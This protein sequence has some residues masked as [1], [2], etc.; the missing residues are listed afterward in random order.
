M[1]NFTKSI[2]APWSSSL[3]GKHYAMETTRTVCC[4][5]LILACQRVVSALRTSVLSVGRLLWEWHCELLY[6]NVCRCVFYGAVTFCVT[7]VQLYKYFLVLQNLSV[8]IIKEGNAIWMIHPFTLL[9]ALRQ[10]HSVFQSE[11]S[12]VRSCASSFNFQYPLFYL[13]SS[14]SFLRLLPRLLVTIWIVYKISFTSHGKQTT[15]ASELISLVRT[16]LL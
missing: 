15:L 7:R 9:S 2:L 8:F 1:V 12:R 16:K 4:A 11:F 5:G 13:R 10:V 3:Q 6:R 14:S